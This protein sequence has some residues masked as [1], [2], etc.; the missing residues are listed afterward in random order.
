MFAVGMSN[1]QQLSQWDGTAFSRR[2]HHSSYLSQVSVGGKSGLG[3]GQQQ[4]VQQAAARGRLRSV[5]WPDPSR[6]SPPITTARCGDARGTDPQALRLAPDLQQPPATIAAAGTVGRES[7]EVERVVRGRIAAHV[8]DRR[9]QHDE[10]VA[11]LCF[12]ESS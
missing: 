5:A 4:P 11:G 2:R 6:T 9:V 8:L 7:L 10:G 1:P 3:P 12:E